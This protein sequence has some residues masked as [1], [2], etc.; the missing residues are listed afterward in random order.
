MYSFFGVPSTLK[1]FSHLIYINSGG[2]GI[3]GGKEKK[4]KEKG[5]KKGKGGREGEDRR[6]EKPTTF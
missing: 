2:K 1:L 3:E 6:S 5:R 4:E